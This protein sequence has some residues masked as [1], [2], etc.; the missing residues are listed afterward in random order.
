[1][2]SHSKYAAQ[3]L[4]A[5]DCVIVQKWDLAVTAG[6]GPDTGL[7]LGNFADGL[8]SAKAAWM[9]SLSIQV[10]GKLP[11]IVPFNSSI[12]NSFCCVPVMGISLRAMNFCRL[13]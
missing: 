11:E 2:H 9:K 6:S 4:I 1:M 12:S 5:A 3:C 10:K 7:L 8:A 13:D